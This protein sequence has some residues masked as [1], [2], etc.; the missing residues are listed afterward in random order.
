M[1]TL[2]LNVDYPSFPAGT[3]MTLDK[4]GNYYDPTHTFFMS[5]EYVNGR[6]D[7]FV[8]T[9]SYNLKDFT[10]DQL[11]AVQKVLSSLPSTPEVTVLVS[12]IDSIAKPITP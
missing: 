7:E 12:Q 10:P 11:S 8:E 9:A 6:P 3:V 1:N 4:D 2:T 5:L